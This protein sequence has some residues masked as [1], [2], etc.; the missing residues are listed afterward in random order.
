MNTF[1]LES[2]THAIE[3]DQT[4]AALYTNRAAAYLMILGYKEV[5]SSHLYLSVLLISIPS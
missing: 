4:N 1:S 5:H 2:Y 3:L